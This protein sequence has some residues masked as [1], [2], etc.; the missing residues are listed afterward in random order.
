MSH[1]TVMVIGPDVEAQL[2]PFHEHECTGIDDEYV[3]DVDMTD[4]VIAQYN[5]DVKVVR[6]ADG[7]HVDYYDDRFYKIS[8]DQRIRRH[9]LPEGATELVLNA[10]EARALS[11]GYATLE[12]AAHYLGYSSKGDGT[13]YQH[14]NPNAKWDWYSIGGR[15]TGLLKLRAG[16]VGRTGRPGLMTESAPPGYA[17]QAFKGDIDFEQMRTDASIKARLLWKMTRD[18]T[19]NQ[20][21]DSWDDTRIR[22]PNIDNA[23][24]EYWDQPAIQLLKASGK[25]AYS[26][27]IDDDLALDEAVYVERRQDSA[28]ITFAFVRDSVWTERGSMGWFGLVSDEISDSQWNKMFNSM[29]DGLPDDTLITIVDCHI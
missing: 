20:T 15:W 11:L 3:V 5:K 18:I 17:D 24:R 7:T 12:S 16:A 25:D 29:L 27:S 28:C 23:R 13:F 26:W 8:L 22:Y 19:N 1:F 14:T 4:K 2:Q 21:W 9:E 6:L 10:D